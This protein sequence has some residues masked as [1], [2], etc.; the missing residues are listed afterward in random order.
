MDVAL[1]QDSCLLKKQGAWED[2]CSNAKAPGYS[3][4]PVLFYPD[5]D[6]RLWHLTRSADLAWSLR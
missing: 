6:R 2:G 1:I 4:N 3:G 5:Y